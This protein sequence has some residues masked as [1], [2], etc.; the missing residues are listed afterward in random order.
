MFKIPES[1]ICHAFGCQD[2]LAYKAAGML[3]SRLFIPTRLNSLLD[4]LIF[5]TTLKYSFV[6]PTSLENF[7]CGR[8]ALALVVTTLVILRSREKK[9]DCLFLMQTDLA[10]STAS[11]QLVQRYTQPCGVRLNLNKVVEF[12]FSHE[13]SNKGIQ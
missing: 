11:V 10:F 6:F 12:T 13:S 8:H 3:I 7:F 2:V 1:L 5:S 4:I 9:C